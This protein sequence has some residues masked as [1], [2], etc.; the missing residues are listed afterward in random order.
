[1]GRARRSSTWYS[2]VR[3]L[4][5]W[6]YGGVGVKGYSY[7]HDWAYV[8]YTR[9]GIIACE[10]KGICIYSFRACPEAAPAV[11]GPQAASAVGGTM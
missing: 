8:H 2:G 10:H 3:G 5:V 4:F 6:G 11:G 7:I 1:M 9:M